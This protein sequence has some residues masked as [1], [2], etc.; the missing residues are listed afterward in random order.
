MAADVIKLSAGAIVALCAVMII[1]NHRPELAMQ[2][3][4]AAGIAILAC[5][6]NAVG[7]IAQTAKTIMMR[8]E[9]DSE[10]LGS[11]VKIIG[12]AYIAQFSSDTCR[13]CGEN[14]LAGKVELVG[15]LMMVAA[16]LP[17]VISTLDAIGGLMGK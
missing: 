5:G 6:V 2:V 3:S 14:S 8:Y 1:R 10:S 16:A 4:I 11:A 15:R 17:L 12:I 13:D 9:L 7:D